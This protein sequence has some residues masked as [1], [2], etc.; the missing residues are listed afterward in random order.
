MT[1]VLFSQGSTIYSDTAAGNYKGMGIFD[2]QL[3]RVPAKRLG[4]TEEVRLEP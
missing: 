4:K 1:C 3:P 2:Q